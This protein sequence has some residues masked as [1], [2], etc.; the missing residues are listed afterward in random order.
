MTVHACMR[1]PPKCMVTFFGYGSMIS[2]CSQTVNITASL[3]VP[4]TVYLDVAFKS[5]LKII[6]DYI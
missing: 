3:C 6:Y 5:T 4:L 2:F 1:F